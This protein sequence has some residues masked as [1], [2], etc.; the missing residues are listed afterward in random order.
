MQYETDIRWV[1]LMGMAAAISGCWKNVP[2]PVTLVSG[3]QT[4]HP[5][6]PEG[7]TQVVGS[8][9]GE[10]DWSGDS[11]STH[12]GGCVLYQEIAKIQS[13]KTPNSC[14]PATNYCS[15]TREG[16]IGDALGTC[17]YRGPDNPFCVKDVDFTEGHTMRFPVSN[18]I[19][20][21]RRWRVSTCQTI[22]GKICGRVRF[23]PITE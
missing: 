13:C 11:S 5:D 12:G 9:Q 7:V 10:V 14:K 23:G 19:A 17:W 16:V 1:L 3:P 21:G 22:D 4:S 18:D 20:A 6:V 15:Q 8:F 2:E